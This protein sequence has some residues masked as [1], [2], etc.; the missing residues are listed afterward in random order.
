[1]RCRLMRR[2]KAADPNQISGDRLFDV[3]LSTIFCHYVDFP[4][5]I[6]ADNLKYAGISEIRTS[7]C[8]IQVVPFA[9][10]LSVQ[11]RYL[12]L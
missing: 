9:K 10:S 4:F 7:S 12:P 1:M 11:A 2:E 6:S 8:G 5:P 3:E